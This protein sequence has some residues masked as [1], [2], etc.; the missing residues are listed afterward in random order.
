[1]GIVDE[2]CTATFRDILPQLVNYN[3]FNDYMRNQSMKT[4]QMENK[5]SLSVMKEYDDEIII[6]RRS[7][8]AYIDNEYY[9]KIMLE[10]KK[11]YICYPVVVT[12][13]RVH[14]IINTPEG[15]KFL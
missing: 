12:G 10:D 5:Q 11:K 7:N 13:V 2:N 9:K 8:C 14:W 6:I 3:N 4:I 15:H 1:M